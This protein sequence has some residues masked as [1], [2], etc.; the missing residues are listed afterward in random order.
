MRNRRG[1]PKHTSMSI[2]CLFLIYTGQKKLL[3]TLDTLLVGLDLMWGESSLICV[4]L[5]SVFL[6]LSLILT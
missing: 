5:P 6:C 4:F 1:L 2:S 3:N